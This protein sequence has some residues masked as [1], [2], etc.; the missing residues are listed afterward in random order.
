[1]FKLFVNHKDRKEKVG[2]KVK[3][4]LTTILIFTLVFCNT[5]MVHAA[6]NTPHVYGAKLTVARGEIINYPIYI[7]GNT[8][9]A[10]IKVIFAS[11]TK[12]ITPLVK[13]DGKSLDFETGEALSTGSA[14]GSADET[15]GQIVW[16]HVKNSKENGKLFIVKLKVAD[17]ARSGNYN[18]KISYSPENTITQ[19]EAPVTCRTTDGTITIKESSTTGNSGSTG[20]AGSGTS[21]SSTALDKENTEKPRDDKA[22][23]PEITPPEADDPTVAETA[24]AIKAVKIKLTTKLTKTKG[25]SSITLT[26][27][28]SKRNVKFDGYDIRR[29]VKKSSGY[30]KRAFALTKKAKYINSRSLKKG[31]TYYYKVRAYKLVDGNKVYTKWSNKSWKTVK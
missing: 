15:G 22:E 20:N 23:Q 18:I 5:I 13:E 6:D 8:G 10:A 27:K 28:L 19:K 1:M 11:E 25:K 2:G 3:K 30:G 26:W 4:I 9:I 7:E 12:G 16:F 14:F 17:N 31:K 21:G 29:S 24:A